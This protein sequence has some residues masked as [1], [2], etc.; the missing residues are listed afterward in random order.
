MTKVTNIVKVKTETGHIVT[1]DLRIREDRS[2]KENQLV[3]VVNVTLTTVS[4]YD[5]GDDVVSAT[6]K[7]EGDF[8]SAEDL[9]SLT[10]CF[11]ANT[12][13]EVKEMMLYSEWN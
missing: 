2:G 3:A 4:Y 5:E 12:L 7:M 6:Y 10:Y 11:D 1:A 9:F 8:V 13:S